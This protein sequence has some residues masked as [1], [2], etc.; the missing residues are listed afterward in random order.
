MP[1]PRPSL[2]SLLPTGPHA[3]TTAPRSPTAANRL[4]A[5]ANRPPTAANRPPAAARGTSLRLALACLVLTLAP[6]GISHADPDVR[7]PPGT[8]SDAQGQLVSGR[9]IRE[10]TDFLARELSRRGIV[11]EQI[12]PYGARGAVVTRFISRTPSTPWLAVHVLRVAGKTVI[13]FVPRA[14]SAVTP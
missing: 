9:G 8:H 5:A 7:L 3:P 10:T 13:F 1:H 4:P 12:G 11:V 6:A 2:L 14:K